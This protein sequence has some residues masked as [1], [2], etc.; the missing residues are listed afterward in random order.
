MAEHGKLL[1]SGATGTVGGQVVKQLREELIALGGLLTQI[2]GALLTLTDLLSAPAHH[3]DRVQM[4]RADTEATPTQR[5]PAAATAC[6]GIAG[7]VISSPTRP[8]GRSTPASGGAH[9]PGRA[10][11]DRE[12]PA[13]PAATPCT[14]PRRDSL[15]CRGRRAASVVVWSQLV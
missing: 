1:V 4:R 5:Q 10:P 12:V 13:V 6:Y 9:G 15:G 3:Y 8:H 2:S 7:T 14:S 11:R